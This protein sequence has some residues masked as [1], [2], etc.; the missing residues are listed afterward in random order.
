MV[1]VK[2][3]GREVIEEEALSGGPEGRGVALERMKIALAK[4][5]LLARD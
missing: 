3:Q 4:R 5:I 2:T 1:W